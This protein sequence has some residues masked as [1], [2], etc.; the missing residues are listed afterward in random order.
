MIARPPAVLG[1]DLGTTEVKAGLV[2]LDGRIL[3]LGRSSY[4]LDV[5]GG[6]GW[7]EQDPGAWWSAVVGRGPGAASDRPRGRRRDRDRRSRPDPR[8][9]R[10]ARRGDPPG[11][12]VP[13]WPGDRRSRAPGG[14]DRDPRLVAW[15]PPRR[16]VGGAPRAR[17]RRRHV[18]VSIDL[19]M[20][21]PPPDRRRQRPVRAR[22]GR[23]RHGS[24]PPRPGSRPIACRRRRRAARSS[25]G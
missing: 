22:P 19:G 1:L 21:G 18:L 6:P 5:D 20:A 8:V 11:D 10:R 25:A 15:R 24:R 14:R 9:G 4:A 17:R 13:R 7:A 2:T 3:A 16:A 23:P 12:H